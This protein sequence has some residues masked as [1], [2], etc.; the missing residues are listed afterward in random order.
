MAIYPV[1]LYVVAVDWPGHGMSSHL[2]NGARYDAFGFV[3]NVKHI[4]DGKNYYFAIAE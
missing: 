3:A 2:P 4:V 1:E